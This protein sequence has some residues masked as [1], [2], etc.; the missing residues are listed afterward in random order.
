MV[1]KK[2]SRARPPINLPQINAASVLM[3]SILTAILVVKCQSY[4]R[5]FT[6]D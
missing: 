5:G 2:P 1:S 4:R 3:I 6:D